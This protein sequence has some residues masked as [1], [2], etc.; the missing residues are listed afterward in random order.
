VKR[1]YR[2]CFWKTSLDRVQEWGE[3][4]FQKF[5]QKWKVLNVEWNFFIETTEKCYSEVHKKISINFIL[6]SINWNN[7]E[8]REQQK[9]IIHW[10]TM[11]INWI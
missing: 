1:K 10:N 5:L 2:R 4:N 3:L 8:I 6:E 11:I 9:E 7:I